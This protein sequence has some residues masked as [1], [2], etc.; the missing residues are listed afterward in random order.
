VSSSASRE[1]RAPADLPE[2][3]LPAG[4]RQ[5]MKMNHVIQRVQKLQDALNFKGCRNHQFRGN[6]IGK[7]GTAG[8]FLGLAGGIHVGLWL[9][10]VIVLATIELNSFTKT[11]CII[12]LHW[13]TYFIFLASFHFSEFFVTAIKQPDSLS[14][15]CEYILD[16]M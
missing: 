8:F 5:D 7:I 14:Y 3:R 9:A 2:Q 16:W 10:L 4:A 12:F 6:G 11:L 15:D 13:S 1:E